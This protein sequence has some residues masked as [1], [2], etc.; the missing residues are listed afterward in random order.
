MGC[1]QNQKAVKGE[2]G[3]RGGR[4]GRGERS[5]RFTYGLPTYRCLILS[6]S[7]EKVTSSTKHLIHFSTQFHRKTPPFPNLLC[8]KSIN[9]HRTP[10]ECLYLAMYKR[11]VVEKRIKPLTRQLNKS[12]PFDSK[13]WRF[14]RKQRP[15][16]ESE[17]KAER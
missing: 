10:P 14:P 6:R 7:T 13:T 16:R 3:K 15:T 2:N 11:R 4:W 5:S 9:A 8:K 1:R 17:I 12:S